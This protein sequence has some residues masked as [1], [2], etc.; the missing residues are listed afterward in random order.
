MQVNTRVR[1]AVILQESIDKV[2]RDAIRHVESK[3][4]KYGMG[5]VPFSPQVLGRTGM[6][7]GHL[8]Y[9]STNDIFLKF[10]NIKI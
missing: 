5:N 3:C 6:T 4:R 2:K 10:K 1:N 7:S 8:S 9:I